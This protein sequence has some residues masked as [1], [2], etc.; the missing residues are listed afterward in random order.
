MCATSKS[1]VRRQY[2]ISAQVLAKTSP[3]IV[4]IS[5]CLTFLIC[6][7]YSCSATIVPAM[8]I[9]SKRWG[10]QRFRLI[11]REIFYTTFS[12]NAVLVELVPQSL[13]SPFTIY[14]TDGFFI[15][16]IYE[17]YLPWRRDKRT[18]DGDSRYDFDHLW[19]NSGQYLGRNWISSGYS[20][21]HQRHTG[22]SLLTI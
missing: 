1:G 12:L 2:L 11:I 22:G 14:H 19:R 9:F 16:G 3:L 18:E 15:L 7:N 8:G 4:K 20:L 5:S 6:F 10:H 13:A 17:G 21:N